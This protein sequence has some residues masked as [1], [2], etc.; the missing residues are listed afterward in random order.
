VVACDGIWDVLSSQEAC[1]FVRER[2]A[3]GMTPLEISSAACDHCIADDPKQTQGIG[4][5]NMTCLVV[6]FAQGE[7]GSK[8]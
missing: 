4:G 6:T 7:G 5:D 1:D 3:M 8:I 2:L